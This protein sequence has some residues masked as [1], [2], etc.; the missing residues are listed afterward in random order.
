MST[1][2]DWMEREI[3]RRGIRKEVEEELARLKLQ[4]AIVALRRETPHT[5]FAFGGDT[6]SPSVFS[7]LFQGR[8]MID[9][10]NALG[11]MAQ[12]WLNHAR[13]GSVFEF[14]YAAQT[15][16]RQMLASGTPPL[17]P[18]ISKHFAT[19]SIKP[20]SNSFVI[21]LASTRQFRR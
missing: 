20:D 11:V 1:F 15:S 4:Q 5:L 9:A 6:L 17:S 12:L 14:G 16:N 13:F 3:D 10:W 21:V 18:R 7:T 19:H 2:N 8:Q